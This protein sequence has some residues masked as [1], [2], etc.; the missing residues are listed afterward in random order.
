MDL[1]DSVIERLASAS[2][3]AQIALVAES[4]DRV[5]PIYEEYWVGTYSEFVRR[6]ID[7][8]WA[9]AC[10]ATVDEAEI[11]TCLTHVGGLV[12]FY[13]EEG[14]DVLAAT[15]TVC[16]R[17]LQAMAPDQKE[18]SLSVA[19]GLLSARETAQAAEAMA[20]QQTPKA[21]RTRVALHEEEAWQN[22][23]F[24]IVAGWKDIAT[25]NMF[26]SLDD[27]PPKWLLD[28]KLRSRR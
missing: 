10:G 3:H 8:G 13:R 7:I 26:D 11:R 16:L 27:K 28:W 12:E 25:R 6:S 17:V 15:V 4:A 1:I 20:N 19:R 24:A 22:A 18:L 23:A 9:H 21:S 5:Y 14:I 2:S